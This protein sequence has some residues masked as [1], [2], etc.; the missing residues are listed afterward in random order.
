[1]GTLSC[2]Y[3]GVECA[4]VEARIGHEPLCPSNPL[5]TGELG[6]SLV[7]IAV[8][9]EYHKHP[10]LG[11]TLSPLATVT[12]TTPTVHA[13]STAF[14]VQPDVPRNII[15]T[16]NAGANEVIRVNGVDAGGGAIYEDFTLSAATPQVGAKA[17]KSF[18]SFVYPAGTHTCAFVLGDVLGLGHK[19]TSVLDVI[20][21]NFNLADDA[22][23][24]AVSSTVLS[25]NTFAMA[26]TLDGTKPVDILYVVR[27]AE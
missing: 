21:N 27:P 15:L 26:G 5:L 13:A 8:L 19:L 18:T 23:T 16:G 7:G 1:M 25:L 12:L 17:F 10:V 2:P 4:T 14:L 3:C 20:Q 24:V 22:G 11:S 6:A 9:A